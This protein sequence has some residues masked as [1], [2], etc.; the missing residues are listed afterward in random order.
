MSSLFKLAFHYLK[1]NKAKTFFI[2]CGTTLSIILFLTTVFFVT[3]YKDS[4]MESDLT[5]YGDYLINYPDNKKEPLPSFIE[6][7]V[8]NQTYL[9]TH[10]FTKAEDG[11]YIQIYGAT[12][13][14][15]ISFTQ[16][17]EGEYPKDDHEI[18]IS[19]NYAKNHKIQI[20][21][22][23]TL[24][25]GN[26]MYNGE[27]V[28]VDT[29]FPNEKFVETKKKEY[30]VTGIFN[31]FT[32]SNYVI[33][34]EA[35]MTISN[36]VNGEFTSYLKLNATREQWE[37]I[38]SQLDAMPQ[39]Y[40]K[41]LINTGAEAYYY[42]K[43]M[44]TME[45]FAYALIGLILFSSMLSMVKNMFN[46]S[47]KEQIKQIGILESIGAT[48]PQILGL[49]LC[50]G[51]LYALL[52]FPLGVII[53]I[54]ISKGLFYYCSYAFTDA[55]SYPISFRLVFEWK[56]LIPSLVLIFLALILSSILPT[57]KIRKLYPIAMIKKEDYQIHIKALQKKHKESKLGIEFDLGKRNRQA[58]KKGYHSIIF[59]LTM[60]IVLFVTGNSFVQQMSR[61]TTGDINPIIYLSSSLDDMDVKNQI[62]KELLSIEKDTISKNSIMLPDASLSL[63]KNA[64][65]PYRLHLTYQMG[66]GYGLTNDHQMYIQNHYE[67]YGKQ[68]G[69]IYYRPSNDGSVTLHLKDQDITYDLIDQTNE[70]KL[71]DIVLSSEDERA[72]NVYI[73]VT[74][75]E[76]NK[77]VQSS[78]SLKDLFIST[79]IQVNVEHKDAVV[80]KAKQLQEQYPDIVESIVDP[81]SDAENDPFFQIMHVIIFV[82]TIILLFVCMANMINT[83]VSNVMAKRR[84]YAM[85]QSVGMDDK[86]LIKLLIYEY[87]LY[88]IKT[89][90]FAVPISLISSYAFYAWLF[91]S[92]KHFVAPT[93]YLLEA[94]GFSLLLVIVSLGVAWHLLQKDSLMQSIKDEVES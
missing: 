44:G 29:L 18:M 28:T 52:A 86:Q 89:W 46:I 38:K 90:I 30:V 9:S 53:S 45:I 51:L 8:T 60:S 1:E 11:S 48:N 65:Q 57:M 25:E 91:T 88:L 79:Q 55:F 17:L 35:M 58:N 77:L 39:I 69:Y 26:R 93:T 50:E 84:D 71:E 34:S 4:I 43:P 31:D 37:N 94:L 42:P 62:E 80:Q 22:K 63:D 66:D 15:N 20:G 3:S 24:M 85:L 27:K 54:F 73:Y 7:H 2:V 13:L 21:D 36:D 75:N 61:V 83:V 72:F 76:F 49:S 67:W 87:G 78:T 47:I 74:E 64:S 5:I 82:F 68:G 59:S 40:G 56:L 19:P 32:A 70:L 33:I 12:D 81:V 10:A 6:E 14:Q 23:I 16:L 92:L 41:Y